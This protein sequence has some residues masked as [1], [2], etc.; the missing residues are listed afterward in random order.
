VSATIKLRLISQNRERRFSFFWHITADG[1]CASWL[2][3]VLVVLLIRCGLRMLAAV[4]FEG[5]LPMLGQSASMTPFID[6]DAGG[7]GEAGH[8]EADKLPLAAAK[9][10]DGV[11]HE[12]DFGEVLRAQAGA[13][14]GLAGAVLA[15][16]GDAVLRIDAEVRFAFVR[17]AS[18]SAGA[19]AGVGCKSHLQLLL[20]S[21]R[22]GRSKSFCGARLEM[23]GVRG[24][25][26]G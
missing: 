18:S 9:A 26:I 3:L 8:G 25:R 14:E 12:E 16:D 6:F 20:S 24:A 21:G 22:S 23:L 7:D 5:V 13:A 2:E 15:L 4:V 11:T 10:T 17:R 19:I 1:V